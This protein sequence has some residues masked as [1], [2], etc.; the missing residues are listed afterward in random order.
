MS[1]SR[2]ARRRWPFRFVATVGVVALAVLGTA[3]GG[4]TG[5]AN[6]QPGDVVGYCALSQQVNTAGGGPT[7]AQVSEL[8]R[9]APPEIRR[10]V[11]TALNA[12]DATDTG[13]Q[14]F[15]RILDYE[16]AHC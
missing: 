4:G 14:A 9:L 2:R 7:P 11:T 10:D 13:V 8:I 5:T 1:T 15:S 3:C 12:G 16:S 6:A